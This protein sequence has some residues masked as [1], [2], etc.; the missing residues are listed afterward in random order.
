MTTSRDTTVGLISKLVDMETMLARLQT[1]EFTLDFDA[2]FLKEIEDD[3][4][5]IQ[6]NLINQIRSP[7]KGK[8]ATISQPLDQSKNKN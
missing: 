5:N 2:I 3:E 1:L 4:F 8:Q 7:V 6:A